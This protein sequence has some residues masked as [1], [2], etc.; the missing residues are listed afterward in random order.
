MGSDEF[1][2]AVVDE[3][4][5]LH[6]F[7]HARPLELDALHR[8]EDVHHSLHPQS[9]NAVAQR[10]EDAAGTQRGP[11]EVGEGGR[12]GGGECGQDFII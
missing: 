10:R 8:L 5:L 3:G 6:G 1:I 7:H 4:V 2:D 11:V 12:G 9:C